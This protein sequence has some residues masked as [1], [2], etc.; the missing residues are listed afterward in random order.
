MLSQIGDQSRIKLVDLGRRLGIELGTPTANMGPIDADVIG[1]PIHHL[2]VDA[3]S[4]ERANLCHRLLALVLHHVEHVDCENASGATGFDGLM[5][6]QAALMPLAQGT[7]YFVRPKGLLDEG[8]RHIAS[9]ADNR[10]DLAVREDRFD[11]IGYSRICRCAINPAPTPAG[12][13]TLSITD[14]TN[15]RV[16]AKGSGPKR[17]R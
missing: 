12:A 7:Q 4:K 8:G 9:V 17:S 15:S 3:D 16:A 6:A 10:N 14:C 11:Q 5:H 13:A 1:K 2:L